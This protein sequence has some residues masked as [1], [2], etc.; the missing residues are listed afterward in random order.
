MQDLILEKTRLL[1]GV[2]NDNGK[3]ME[4]KMHD[5]C[6]VFGIY[7]NH[8]QDV[9]RI[10][11]Y[12]LYGLQHR[13]QESSGIAVTD[14]KKF[15]LKRGMGLVRDV[16]RTEEDIANLG[17]G[18]IAIGH[19]RYST[20]GSSVIKNA[21]PFLLEKDGRQITIAHNGNL[22]NPGQLRK[23]VTDISLLSTTDT[24][25]VGALLL[26]SKKTTWEER[27]DEVLPQVKGAYSYV[28]A[29]RDLLFGARDPFGIRPLVL[30]KLNGGWVLS[31]EDCIFPAIGATYIRDIKPGEAVIIDKNG[32]KTF[33]QQPVKQKGFCIF[34]YVYIA[35]PDST[36]EGIS[37]GK[38]RERCGEILSEESPVDA[39]FVMPIPY[40]GITAAIAYA[41]KAKLPFREGVITN[42]Y[43][44]RTFIEP[45]QR[46]R[47]IGIK[48]KFG[49]MS[50]NLKG[51]KVIVV[52]DSIVR[53]NTL[54]DFVKMLRTYGAKEVH[55]RIA[56]P[57]LTDPC[58]YGVDTP[59]KEHLIAGRYEKKTPLGIHQK[60]V[61]IEKIREFLGADTLAYLSLRELLKATGQKNTDDANFDPEKTP[62]CMA[63]MNGVYKIPLGG[64]EHKFI[65]E[66]PEY[67]SEL[68]EKR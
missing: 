10:T 61:D 41:A 44:G 5:Q 17:K 40:S 51:K 2:R 39:D 43:I 22:I 63:C 30:G 32:P 56:S 19:N 57:P 60:D 25:I 16:F 6:A 49:P 35:R 62:F 1:I 18:I 34:E 3:N 48:L 14:G 50:A 21:H 52:D 59:K 55:L 12:A 53:G 36:L 46:M 47:E 27:F 31:S 28:I 38:V 7:D 4:D 37:V 9:A 24:E 58:F 54:R 65:L 8:S 11:Y 29:T 64:G 13:G 15:T 45:D 33:Y 23:K 20:L 67:P 42:R 66:N 68:I 26:Q